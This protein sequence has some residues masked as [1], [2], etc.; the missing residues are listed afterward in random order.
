MQ[1]CDAVPPYPKTKELNK[2]WPSL[3]SS[4]ALPYRFLAKHNMFYVP[5]APP[6][7]MFVPLTPISCVILVTLIVLT[8]VHIHTQ[9]QPAPLNN[10]LL[11][12]C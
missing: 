3:F 12:Q 11:S 5:P 8:T 4:S 7:A 2:P 10:L 9:I 6:L 1:R